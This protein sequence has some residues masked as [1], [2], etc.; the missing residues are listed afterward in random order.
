MR[1]RLT[2]VNGKIEQEQ[3]QVMKYFKS[4]N[5]WLGRQADNKKIT[6]LEMVGSAT[7]QSSG[8]MW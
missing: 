8:K 1:I 4:I 6:M 2:I 3:R 7:E 5:K